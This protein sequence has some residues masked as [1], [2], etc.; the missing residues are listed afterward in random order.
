MQ[1]N[2]GTRP[3]VR[4]WREVICIRFTRYFEDGYRHFLGHRC[5]AR[6]PL[7][8]RPALQNVFRSLITRCR[9]L[10]NV[11]KGIEHEDHLGESPR[12]D[13]GERRVVEGV[14]QRLNVVATHHGTQQLNGVSLGNERRGSFARD[15]CREE[16]RLDVSSLVDARRNTMRQ[17]LEQFCSL[18]LWRR[19]Q[20]VDET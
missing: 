12:C 10:L 6:K 20:Q 9:L 1:W 18:I 4:R 15:N 7:G 19:L 2:V 11:V 14:N 16:A 3:S 8:I 5:P 13:V 17:Q